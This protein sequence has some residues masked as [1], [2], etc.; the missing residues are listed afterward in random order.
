MKLDFSEINFTLDA[1]R[2]VNIKAADA[3]YVS[4][5]IIKLEKEQ[6]RLGKLEEKKGAEI[7]A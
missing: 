2:S 6:E 7:P 5:L 3:V 4:G 1:V